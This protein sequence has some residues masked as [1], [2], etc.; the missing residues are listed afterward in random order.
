[1]YGSTRNYSLLLE[2]AHL[3]EGLGE[4]ISYRGR[5]LISLKTEIVD[6]DDMGPTMVDVE[7][8]QPVPEVT[9]LRKHWFY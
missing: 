3:N 5:L 2:H 6:A 1:M 7:M 4:G 8:C 9:F